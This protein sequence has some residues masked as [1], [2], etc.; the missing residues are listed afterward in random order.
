LFI[1]NTVLLCVIKR[2]WYRNFTL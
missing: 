1:L 2:I